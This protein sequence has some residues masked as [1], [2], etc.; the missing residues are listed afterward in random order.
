MQI[1]ESIEAGSMETFTL[2][3]LY[4]NKTALQNNKYVIRE[5]TYNNYFN[6]C[7]R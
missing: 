4:W 5:I 7:Y 1:A 2:Q 3:L 6:Y